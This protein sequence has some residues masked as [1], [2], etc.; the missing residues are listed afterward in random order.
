MSIYMKTYKYEICG[1]T[2][3]L[4]YVAIKEDLAYASFVVIGDTELIQAVAKELARKMQAA[5][6]I[7]TAEA[8]GI[9]LAYE[10]SRILN[11]K[12]FIVAR[13][14]VKSYMKNIVSEKVNSIT[15]T[16]EQT[17]YLDEA[18][19]RKVAGK[20]VCL[21]DD[22]ISTGESL[23]AL[24]RLAEKAKA[25]VVQKAAILAEGDAANRKDILF[26]KKLP[27]FEITKDGNYIELV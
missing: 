23:A 1:L 20:R 10:I 14:S 21:L 26:L 11:H 9:A 22:V 12:S 13:K 19:A 5:D 24:V 17:L 27:L 16:S 3:E 6:Y 8:K 18:D 25:K 7:M 15:T 4:P 2:R